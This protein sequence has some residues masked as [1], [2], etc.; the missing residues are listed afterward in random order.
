VC[1]AGLVTG[2]ERTLGR[3]LKCPGTPDE[4]LATS[5]R[6]WRDAEAQGRGLPASIVLT[7]ETLAAL[8]ERRPATEAD[9]RDSPG[10]RSD[11]IAD[12][13]SQVLAIVAAASGPEVD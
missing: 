12:Y 10:F 5:L 2:R 1:G 9:L 4:R 11:K 7:D 13:G 6:E 8:E 3:C